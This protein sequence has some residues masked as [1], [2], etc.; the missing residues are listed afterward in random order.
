MQKALKF[1]TIGIIGHVNHGS[2]LASEHIAKELCT[3]HEDLIVVHDNAFS[4]KD[5]LALQQEQQRGIGI[6][7]HLKDK[8]VALQSCE[9][10]FP[11]IP[12]VK[13]H[14]PNTGLKIGSYRYKK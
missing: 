9:Y 7:T 10:A 1:P 8:Q 4:E 5:L 3:D 11:D 14:K 6:T 12:V 2:L 13:K